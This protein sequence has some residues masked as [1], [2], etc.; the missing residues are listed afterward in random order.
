MADEIL[1]VSRARKLYPTFFSFLEELG[2]KNLSITALER[3]ALFSHIQEVNPKMVFLDSNFRQ[4]G[5]PCFVGELIKQFP[6]LHVVAVAYN[7]YPL[8]LASWFIWHGAKS[9]LHLCADGLD[10]FKYG[11]REIKKGNNYIAPAIQHVM[12]LF[13]EWPLTKNHITKR[14]YECLVLLCNGFNAD[15]IAMELNLSRKTI[16]CTLGAMFDIFHVHSKEALIS[17]AWVSGLVS[18][19]DLQFYR[20][21]KDLKLP[22]WAETAI[23]TNKKLE[24]FYRTIH[25]GDE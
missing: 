23:L 20:K 18:K 12:G 22:E 10:E 6:K 5:T 14:Q 9:C 13:S 3:D 17:Y 2:F 1:L 24:E 15:S 8:Y 11:F 4:A 21:D 16:D 25:G 19:H 7:D